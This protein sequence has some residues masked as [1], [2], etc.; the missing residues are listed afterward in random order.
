[1]RKSIA[2]VVAIAFTGAVALTGCGDDSPQVVEELTTTRT[3]TTA[4]EPTTTKPSTSRIVEPGEGDG[5][6]YDTDP[7]L[8][9]PE[10]LPPAVG[11]APEP[12]T[13]AAEPAPPDDSVTITESPDAGDTSGSETSSST[14]RSPAPPDDG[15]RPGDDASG[16]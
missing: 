14:T 8:D 2:T 12:T 10:P 7:G 1:M 4:T 9:Y 3:T 15:A 11:G 16:Q 6:F 5:S 13:T